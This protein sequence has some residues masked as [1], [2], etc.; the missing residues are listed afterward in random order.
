MQGN[1]DAHRRNYTGLL[2]DVAALPEL[3]ADP[4]LS[5]EIFS[6]GELAPELIPQALKPKINHHHLPYQVLALVQ[7]AVHMHRVQVPTGTAW[8]GAWHMHVSG[9]NRVP[10]TTHAW[11]C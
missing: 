1:T 10:C 6:F 2:Q 7:A 4:R 11:I 9:A 8:H 5:L 3:V